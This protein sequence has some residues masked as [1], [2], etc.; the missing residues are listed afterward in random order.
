[1][2]ALYA[3]ITLFFFFSPAV[4][5][6]RR[7]SRRSLASPSPAACDALDYFV[8][9]GWTFAQAAGIVGNLIV[10]SNLNP[11]AVGD[12]GKAYGIAQ[13]HP[14][15]QA[16]CSKLL[17][18]PIKG[19]SVEEQLECVENEFK[20]SES[21]AAAKIKTATT[22]ADAAVLCDQYYERSSG[23]A[24]QNRITQAN[25]LANGGCAKGNPAPAPKPAPAPAPKPAPKP[26]PAPTPKPINHPKPEPT[27]APEPVEA[28]T[29]GKIVECIRKPGQLLSS[30]SKLCQQAAKY[31]DPRTWNEGGDSEDSGD[32][33]YDSGDS[34]YGLRGR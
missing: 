9:Q 6:E 19:S 25:N 5:G 3:L 28:P 8:G 32:S 31:W 30:M 16:T 18:R 10:E 12:S 34:G 33:G 7:K 1:M 13:W 20:T 26:E 21:R 14:D 24:R 4:A 29:V 2:Q 15:R 17:N 23:A 27:P 11:A 22:A